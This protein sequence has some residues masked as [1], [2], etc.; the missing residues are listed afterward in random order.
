MARLYI[1]EAGTHGGR[2]L[3]IGVLVVPDHAALHNA[4]VRIKK[5][6]GYFNTNPKLKNRLRETHLAK[7]KRQTDL[8]VAKEWLEQFI[9]HGCYYRCIVVDWDIWDGSKFGDPF[10]ADSLRKRRAYKKWLE[11]LLHPEV[12]KH[13]RAELFLD[14]L[15]ICHGYEILQEIQTRF[16]SNYE[17][18]VPWIKSFQH[19]DSSK[20]SHQCLQL[21][22]LI[23]GCVYQSLVPSSNK[24]KLGAKEYSYKLLV[25]V[26]VKSADLGYW[27]GFDKSSLEKH[28]AKF[29]EWFWT[30]TQTR[31]RPAG[32]SAKRSQ[33][34]RK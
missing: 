14:N 27:R 12:K 2:W 28:F 19:T 25:G 1:D 10:E 32:N 20:D 22:D 13:T 18:G 16:T 8:E 5:A 26:G 4:L 34:K 30:P 31:V 24:Y 17:G 6:H 15:V 3:V 29:S 11:M 21:C 7:F 9:A 33:K 23:T